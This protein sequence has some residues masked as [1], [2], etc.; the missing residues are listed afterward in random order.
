MQHETETANV[1]C[2]GAI[3]I[4]IVVWFLFKSHTF[5]KPEQISQSFRAEAV[6]GNC[7][8]YNSC[9]LC[10][11]QADS[12][13]SES[14]DENPEALRPLTHYSLCEQPQTDHLLILPTTPPP[15]PRH[16]HPSQAVVISQPAP[17]CSPHQPSD[18]AHPH[19]HSSESASSTVMHVSVFLAKYVGVFFFRVRLVIFWIITRV[20]HFVHNTS[21]FVSVFASG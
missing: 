19:M 4:I 2:I 10:T 5:S 16:L 15:S 13:L 14:E 21:S 9:V 20:T 12:S 6:Y 17:L 11:G 8:P 1:I 3:I 7:I 18:D